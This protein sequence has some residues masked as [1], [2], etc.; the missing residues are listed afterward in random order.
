MLRPSI[1]KRILAIAVGLI[2]LMAITSVLSTVMTRKVAHQLDEL[3]GKYVEAYGHLARMNVRSLEQAL[4]VRRMVIAK[5]QSPPD[6]AA[7]AEHQKTYEA[8]D[9]EIDKEAQAA[10][11]L[12]NAIIDDTSTDSDNARLGRIDDRIENVNKDLRR[13]LSDENKRMLP[14]LAS[15]NFAEVRASLARADTLR[16]DFNQKVEE[17]RKDMLVQV[18]SDAVVTMRD[19][20]KA[21]VISM[22]LT[23]LAAVLGLMFAIFVSM[24]I[25]RPVRRLLDGTRAV[26]AGRLD[27]SIDVT[28]RDEI[29]QLT[30]AF[31]NMVEQLRHKEKMRETFGRYI[32]PRVVEGLIN[33]QSL[34]TTDGERRVMTVLFCD[35]K[36]FTSLST[37]MTPQG[38][39]K[40]MNHYLST[41]SGPIRNHHG[42]I[43]KYIGDAIMAYWGP[44][45]NEDG[46][47]A[48]LACL[49]AID[50]ARRGTTLRTELPELLGVRTVP[51]D[52][53][54]RIGVATGEVLVGSIGSEFMMSYTVMGDA[55][56]LASRLEGANKAYGSHCLVSAPTIAAAG[57]GL[58]FREIDRLVV[59]GQ[60]QPETVF[61]IIGREDELT[62][63]QVSLLDSYSKGLAAY[64]ERRWD[65]ARHAFSAGLEAVPGDGPSRVFI[66]RIG[67]FQANPPAADWDG[68]WI[69]DQK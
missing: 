10:R 56:N 51:S 41:M 27:G 37:G 8:K 52:C 1:R 28:T 44:P 15:G 35:M 33:R 62:P 16:D 11:V 64:R 39:V 4:A 31:N 55:V 69:L 34:T 43:D 36:G 48:R 58:A 21:I 25:T 22:I 47:Q 13:Y 60:S 23:V 67:E 12:I 14:L 3:S 46:E 18:R 59:V 26:E 32:D 17:I 45:F 40:V 5:T 30:S 68:A 61:E 7:F 53:D 20:Q 66:K 63:D 24:G 54:V 19:Q 29:G 9:L 6:D 2:V 49:A 65:D 57:D 38:L 50:M 42:I